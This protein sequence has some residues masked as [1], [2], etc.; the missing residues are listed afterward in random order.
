MDQALRF[1]LPH[2]DLSKQVR[3]ESVANLPHQRLLLS[4]CFENFRK[5]FTCM[6]S[7]Q[8]ITKISPLE[9][10]IQS[11]LRGL[12]EDFGKD[13]VEKSKASLLMETNV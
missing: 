8:G 9:Y 11:N 7:T 4:L 1:S 2:L 5:F 10:L 3:L 13:I 12:Q 6:L